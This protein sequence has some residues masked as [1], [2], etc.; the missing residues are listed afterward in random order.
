MKA[1]KVVVSGV[2]GQGTLLTSRLL[3]DAGVKAGLHVL[4]GETY[5][6]AQ[7]GGPV[8]GHVQLGG[9]ASNPQI[10]RSEA[11]AILGFEPAE[12][13]RRGVTYLKD[14]GLA[15]VNTRLTVPVEVISGLRSYPELCELM[16]LLGGVTKWIRAFDATGLAET[17]GDPITTNIVMLG[18]LT[19]SGLLPYSVEIVEE[20]IKEN[21]RPR[22]LGLNMKAFRLGREAF[23]K[24]T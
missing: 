5:G 24:F 13:V 21:I 18:A 12:A 10:R 6:M 17:A 16:R 20:A 4:I 23:Y 11:D 15:L 22:Y 8:M 9:R 7:R 19:E 1:F 14:D 3:A 2:G